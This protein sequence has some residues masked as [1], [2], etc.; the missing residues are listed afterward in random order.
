MSRVVLK[1]C[2][3]LR[4]QFEVQNKS[5]FI[6]K[7]VQLTGKGIKTEIPL[8]LTYFISRI[9]NDYHLNRS[10][11]LHFPV[12]PHTYFCICH[13]LYFCNSLAHMRYQFFGQP[14]LFSSVLATNT[15]HFSLINTTL[16]IIFG[17]SLLQNL[18]P[19]LS[20]STS[21]CLV[22]YIVQTGSNSEFC[23]L[24]HSRFLSPG[25]NIL[26]YFWLVLVKLSLILKF[27]WSTSLTCY[28]TEIVTLR[29]D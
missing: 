17:L 18:E 13:V 21:W 26:F 6:S 5:E 27:A 3:L 1:F 11:N 20:I 25:K 14:W 2:P 24:L 8:H 12:T 4:W 23:Q 22:L 29:Q 16:A 19:I 10:Y 28:F 7:F 9:F 15:S